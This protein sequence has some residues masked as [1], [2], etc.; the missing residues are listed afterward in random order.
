MSIKLKLLSSFTHQLS[1]S[2]FPPHGTRKW[3]LKSFHRDRGTNARM[4]Q[5]TLGGVGY[6]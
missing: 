5:L 6:L 4:L 3:R 1:F 2:R